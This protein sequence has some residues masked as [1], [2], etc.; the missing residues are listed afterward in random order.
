MQRAGRS[1]SGPRSAERGTTL[2][3]VVVLVA[4]VALAAA[5]GGAALAQRPAQAT[6][7]AAA[8]AGLVSE[9]R[10]LAAITVGSAPGDGS[11]ATIGV[12]STA[13]GV[14]ATLYAY[15]PIQGAVH[16]PVRAANSVPLMAG[17]TLA[18]AQNGTRVNP[19]F[20]F[21]FS[22][23]GHVSAAVPFTVGSNPALAGEPACPAATGIVIAFLDGV[24]D[25]A[26]VLSCE[27][28][29]LDLTASAALPAH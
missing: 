15:R 29:Q 18:V 4:L 27:A 3:E 13:N 12:V 16:G 20:A 19:P 10:A 28:A 2:L 25:G 22:P 6:T 17:S 7:D 11:G 23:S 5:A 9:A 26:H 14:V 24:H 21:F 8:F 1:N